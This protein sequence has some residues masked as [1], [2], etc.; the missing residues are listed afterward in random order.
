MDNTKDKSKQPAKPVIAITAGDPNG[1][2]YEVIIKAL[3]HPHILEL[4]T[5]VLYGNVPVARK[6]MQLLDKEMQTLQ[7]NLVAHAGEAEQG[8]INLVKCYADDFPLSIGKCTKEAGEAAY[9]SLANACE[10]LKQQR[11]VALVTAPINKENIQSEH[12]HYSGHTEYLTEQFS[13]T[14]DSL[15]M[16]VSEQMRIALVCN[17]VAISKVPLFITEEHILQK[18][19]LLNNTLQSDF[20]IRRPRIAV[21][22]LNPHAGDGGLLGQEE[23]NIIMPAIKKAYD[24]GIMA[25]GP[26]SADG[27]F[28]AGEYSH[29][30]AVL[31]MYH[32]QGLI[33]FKTLDMQGVNFTA[34][35]NIIRTSPDHGTAYA[36]AGKNQ[37]DAMSFRNALYMAIDLVKRRKENKALQEHAMKSVPKE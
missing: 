23:Q 34:G 19:S 6:H 35:L 2:G 25:F 3:S 18:L 31:G 28:G 4:C 26:Y 8:K 14:G 10:D 30:D 33:P 16:M 15:M 13:A 9:Q 29:F 36:I 12:F 24:S 11:V 7:F 21:L 17:H 32:D 20:C 27:F 37:A 22:A 1:I 5:P